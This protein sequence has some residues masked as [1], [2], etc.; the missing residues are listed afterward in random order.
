[1]IQPTDPTIIRVEDLCDADPIAAQVARDAAARR[2]E[3][4]VPD[5]YANAVA[6]D[7]N[8]IAWVEAIVT[9]AVE[10]SRSDMLAI[11][12]GPTL[13]IMGLV[14]RGKT[15]Q[16]YGALRALAV[17]GIRCPW[18][19]VNGPELYAR[20]RP[21][22]GIDSEAEFR[23]IAGAPLLVL[24]DL[25][26]NT[27]DTQFVEEVNYRLIEH[28]NP[29]RLPT[30]IT[31]NVTPGELKARFGDRVESRMRE[32]VTNRAVVEGEDRRQNARQRARLAAE[33]NGQGRAA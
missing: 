3:E 8:V 33:I 17:S 15:Y 6:D 25:G 16:A 2:V 21:R 30:L 27:K 22:H 28:R 23:S 9:A 14:G 32:F 18:V 1:M 24:D 19:F 12:K 10:G 13:M 29:R 11:R 31:S 26:A 5:M 7:P 4:T 20:L